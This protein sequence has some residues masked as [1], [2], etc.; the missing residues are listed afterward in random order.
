MRLTAGVQGHQRPDQEGLRDRGDQPLDLVLVPHP[1]PL[2]VGELNDAPLAVVQIP[3]QIDR[4]KP[5]SRGEPEFFQFRIEL[6][7]RPQ[8]THDSERIPIDAVHERLA[9]IEQCPHRIVA[10][11]L[12][13]L[14]PPPRRKSLIV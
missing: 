12:R 7:S 4:V 6:E 10:P 13:H 9:R 5:N 3:L 11:N 1:T 2:E 8:S 14:L